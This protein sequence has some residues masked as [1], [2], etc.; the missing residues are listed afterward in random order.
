SSA[1]PPARTSPSWPSPHSWLPAP[2]GPDTSSAPWPGT[3]CRA[4]VRCPQGVLDVRH[5]RIDHRLHG[6]RVT[7]RVA[8]PRPRLLFRLSEGPAEILLALAIVEVATRQLPRP[9]GDQTVNPVPHGECFS[10]PHMTTT[11]P[12]GSSHARDRSSPKIGPCDD[13]PSTCTRS[14]VA[15]R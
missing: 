14:R 4:A 7:L 9:L 11:T 3:W 15:S 13:T 2:P 12:P 5:A 10:S 8:H 1:P 6:G